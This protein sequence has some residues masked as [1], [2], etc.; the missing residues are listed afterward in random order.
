MTKFGRTGFETHMS[1][2]DS[3][4]IYLEKETKHSVLGNEDWDLAHYSW[5][6]PWARNKGTEMPFHTML[7]KTVNP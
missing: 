6:L 7:I 1:E 3:R 4:I 5:I 2:A